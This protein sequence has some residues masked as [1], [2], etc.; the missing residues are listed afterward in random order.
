MNNPYISVVV[1]TRNDNYG[2]N[3]AQRLNMF[4]SGLDYYQSLHPH[5]FELVIVEWNPPPSSESLSSI[6]P[7][8][9]N[10]PIRIITVSPE[11]HN[12]LGIKR[13]LA[14]WPAKNVG[15][16]RTRSPF[17]LIA[18]PDILLSKELVESLAIRNLSD[19]VIYRCDRYDF[20]GNGISTIEPAQYTSWA[21]SRIFK[22]HGMVG[23]QSATVDVDLNASDNQLPI[24][25]FDENTVHTNGAGDFMLIAKD[26]AVRVGGF[27]EGAK[28]Q[29]HG[30]SVSMYRFIKENISHGVFAFP[31]FTLH[32]D[33][34]RN[35]LPPPYD[36]T[37]VLN[38]S[39]EPSDPEWGLNNIELAEW[40][41]GL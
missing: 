18:N 20:D 40:N 15:L 3:M 35:I 5:L 17:V 26:T 7:T 10:L 6:I 23:A 31:C 27:Y 11:Y 1:T 29:G 19:D 24:S 36:I 28:C 37:A 9:N 30:D 41:N 13:S 4:I 33:H 22:F 34:D 14:E 21:L 39:H 12:K 2:E 25:Y 8:C 32:H 38:A 16:R